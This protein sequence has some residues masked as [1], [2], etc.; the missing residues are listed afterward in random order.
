MDHRSRRP[1]VRNPVLGLPSARF[2]Q[3][4]PE[5]IRLL[6]SVLLLDL[7]KDARV[8]ARTS[9]DSR[10]AFLAA[11]WATVAVYSGHIGRMLLPAGVRRRRKPFRIV[12]KGYPDLF[13]ADWAD[14]SRLYGHRR[15]SLGLGASKFPEAAMLVED[16]PVGRISYNGRI[17]LPGEWKNG[18][19][20]LYDN[21]AQTGP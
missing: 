12:Q 16:M 20:P 6:L 14:A 15:D 13:A 2:L 9:W 1:E 19:T 7:A 4:S 18:D 3:A 5:A 11:Y 10:K 8:R 21:R 17:W